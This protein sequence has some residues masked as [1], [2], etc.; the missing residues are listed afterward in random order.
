[1]ANNYSQPFYGFPNGFPPP[2]FHPPQGAPP[3]EQRGAPL[4]Q[5]LPGINFNAYTQNGQQ[6]PPPAPSWPPQLPPDANLWALFQNGAFPPPNLP[7]PPFAPMGFPPPSL[8]Q[9]PQNLALPTHFP[10]PFA[11]R[12]TH[13]P[14]PPQPQ[15]TA[16]APAPAPIPAHQRIQKI[17]DSDR[18]DGEVSETDVSQPPPPAKVNGRP[19]PAPAPAPAV[20]HNGSS[21]ETTRQPQE[22]QPTF[23]EK[24]QQ[25]RE[26]AKQFIK[27]LHSNNI[28]YRT[29]ADEKLD[30]EL[31]RGLYQSMNLPSEPA[32]ILPPKPSSAPAVQPAAAPQPSTMPTL[33]TGAIPAS[34]AKAIAS[35]T[36]PGDRKDYIARLQAAKAAKQAGTSKPVSPAQQTMPAKPQTPQPATTPTAKPPVTDEQRAR[37]TEL[38][39][40]RLEAIKARQ[41]APAGASN[42]ARQSS[43]PSQR[44]DQPQVT[45]P[46]AGGSATPTNQSFAPS[47]T[48]IPGL[49]MNSTPVSNTAT[50]TVSQPS[51]SVSQ[52]THALRKDV[53]ASQGPTT[54]LDRSSHARTEDDSMIM[55]VSEDESNGSDMDI[56]DDPPA[57][58]ITQTPRQTPGNL[59]NFASHAGSVLSATTAGSTPG[60][61]T[62][63]TLA[64]EKELADKEKQLAVMRETLK[65]KFA[66]KRERDRIAS[67]A[68]ASSPMAQKAS[69]AALPPQNHTPTK[70]ST[71]TAKNTAQSRRAEIQSKLPTLDAEIAS[72]TSR[73]AELAKELEQL[74]ALNERIAR[75]KEQLTKE[76]ESLGVDTEGMSHAEL[77]AKKDEIEREQS[78]QPNAQSQSVD[79]APQ[80][81][82]NKNPLP[83]RP[84]YQNSGAGI[85][86]NPKTGLPNRPPLPSQPPQGYATLP[87]LGQSTSQAQ[88]Q[89]PPSTNQVS[90]PSKPEMTSNANGTI[91]TAEDNDARVSRS[92][93]SAAV[94]DGD[95]GEDFYDAP[96]PAKNGDVVQLDAS[97]TTEPV[98]V[99]SPSEE[100]EVEMSVSEG[101]D[102]EDEEEYEPEYDPE[103]HT[104]VRDAST[105]E[106]QNTQMSVP[107][108]SASHSS[109][110]DEE[111]YE[112]PDADQEMI[113]V[114][115]E[116]PPLD[117]L[118]QAGQTEA[119]DGAMDIASSSD[120]SSDDS[121]SDSD[122][123]SDS[124][125]EADNTASRINPVRPVTNIADDL[126]PELQPRTISVVDVVEPEPTPEEKVDDEPPQFKPYESPLRMFKSYRYHPNYLQDVPGGFLSTTFSHQI[127]PDTP[128]C[129]TEVEGGTCT[130]PECPA[131]HFRDAIITGDKLLL[132][133][134]T[135]NPGKTS[136]EK[137][138]WNDGLRGVL[139]EL[140]QRNIKDPNGIAEE[141]ARYRRQFLNDDTRVV[142]L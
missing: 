17:M 38:I 69:T 89:T 142:N 36:A 6:P 131:Q 118:P 16:S 139:K 85:T 48:G 108:A 105:A 57:P 7:P 103:E 40:Q 130:Y 50:P 111:A 52:K 133:L 128:F 96:P 46:A 20:Q 82:A 98:T 140:R 42:G 13:P 93:S 44:V 26:S 53:P 47:F 9:T 109:A 127:D 81:S 4:L 19:P 8:P 134:G 56:D 72:N 110:E 100:G 136:E 74:T 3:E 101:E 43:G 21:N 123:E 113:D 37:N 68:A 23:V 92:Q 71:T 138:R 63:S 120:D 119:E 102:G 95:M 67:A 112:P 124:G 39:K 32:P 24:L 80:S 54:P 34:S 31:L 84:S 10:P 77:R 79:S 55:Q 104:V 11:Q 35:P 59:P 94:S 87:G 2:Q 51:P 107:P 14:A 117:T 126:A 129:Q 61:Q 137:Q 141:I 91:H 60:P 122:E 22:N 45:E 29:L 15:Q 97:A 1:M 58:T 75:D 33:K 49:F 64:R 30:P 5:Q 28:P 41:K 116:A 18:E 88:H 90:L 76:L 121:D 27:L 132:Q 12:P 65:K 115:A 66:E 106:A 73:M 83:V 70:P 135:A 25:D 86:G 125:S 99:P 114:Q 78:P 62:P